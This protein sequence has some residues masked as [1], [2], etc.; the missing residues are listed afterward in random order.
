MD[1]FS[2]LS[3]VSKKILFAEPFYGL[4]LIGLKKNF[5]T[6]IPTACVGRNEI[7]TCLNINPDFFKGLD[8]NK[9]YGLIKHELLHIA[10]GHLI[11]RDMYADKKLFNI[12]ADLEI[13]Q[14][15]KRE[16]L[17]EGGLTLDTFPELNLPYKAGTKKYYELLQQAN[18]N[19]Q[20]ESLSNLLDSM[21]GNTPYDH[22]MWDEFD[23]MDEATKKLIQKQV[24]H[25]IKDVVETIEK[26]RGDIPGEMKSIIERIRFVQPQKFDW[27][28][29]LKRFVGNSSKVYTKKTRRKINKR[30]LGNPALKIKTKNHVLVGI[31]TSAS[32]N[33]SE[34]KEF[35]NELVHI[36]KTGHEI[37]IAQCDTNITSV[38]KLNVNADFK[39]HGRGGTDFQPVVDLFNKEKKYT[40]LIYFTD[41]ECYAPYNC[42]KRT[43][44]VLS[45]RSE[46]NNELPGRVI[47]LN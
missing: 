45:S 5:I 24:D 34:L 18:K 33:D 25:Q 21:E 32:V 42:P 3:K 39:I 35:L 40:T 27:K 29:Y 22:P 7:N 37:T 6:A 20:S 23:E 10:F 43:L 31:D 44:W 2:I 30:Y 19:G 46:M 41:G 1:N 14:Y 47:K 26:S 8:D 16:N 11:M 4:F 13:N 12:A 38:E 15:I 28:G 17:P 9:K 36:S